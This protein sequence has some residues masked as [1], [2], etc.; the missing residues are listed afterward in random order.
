[1]QAETRVAWQ[2]P[3]KDQKAHHML[4]FENATISTLMSFLAHDKLKAA[5]KRSERTNTQ[6]CARDE[7]CKR[8][9]SANAESRGNAAVFVIQGIVVME[10]WM[11]AIV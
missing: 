11:D 8:R 7:T 6:G 9:K 1:M 3:G 4:L 10:E 5:V 2:S